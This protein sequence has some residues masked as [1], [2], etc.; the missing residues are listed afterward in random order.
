VAD[1]HSLSR[2]RDA[3]QHMT[4]KLYI[5]MMSQPSRAVLLFCLENGIAHQVEMVQIAKGQ[6]RSAEFKALNPR[7]KVPVIDHDGF[8]LTESH[9]ILAYLADI[10]GLDAWYPR[11]P[12]KR[13]RVDEWLHW[14]HSNL[15]Y[16]AYVV[17]GKVLGPKMGVPTLKEKLEDA[18]KTLHVSLKFMDAALSQQPYLTGSTLSIADLSLACEAAQHWIAGNDFSK[19]PNVAA[20]LKRVGA[21]KNWDKVNAVLY[22]V[23]PARNNAAPAAAPAPAPVPAASLASKGPTS[24]L[25]SSAVFDLIAKR[26]PDEGAEMAKQANAVFRFEISHP[27]LGAPA[28]WT[29]DLRNTGKGALIAGDSQLLADTTFVMSDDDFIALAT[30]KLNPQQA[31]MAQKIKIKGNLGLALRFDSLVLKKRADEVKE[32]VA[33]L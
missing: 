28:K 25:K 18:E 8:V 22:K 13:A 31:F 1:A 4:L 29:V 20:W 14:H 12:K 19:Y 24:A 32:L 6:T 11:D 30:G 5:D 33:K 17:F 7:G 27:S 15:R 23:T 21:L 3:I 16:G 10:H 2:A 9:A 26:L